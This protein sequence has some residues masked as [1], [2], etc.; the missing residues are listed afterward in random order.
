MQI[1]IVQQ[2]INE[3]VQ[4]SGTG[5]NTYFAKAARWC[6]RSGAIDLLCLPY[7]AENYD[8][9]S[10]TQETL[11]LSGNKGLRELAGVRLLQIT[12]TV[13]QSLARENPKHGRCY[14][15]DSF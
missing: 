4:M 9:C 7:A 11:D 2:S 15:I 14:E 10:L 1:E 6:R 13:W 3:L 12:R 5:Q 8:A